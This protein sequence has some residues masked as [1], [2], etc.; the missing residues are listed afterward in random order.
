VVAT[1]RCLTDRRLSALAIV[2]RLTPSRHRH[3]R[4][5]QT[6]NLRR[7]SLFVAAGVR[8]MNGR[9]R[10][11]NDHRTHSVLER[12]ER[13]G[14]KDNELSAANLNYCNAFSFSVAT[15]VFGCEKDDHYK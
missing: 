10:P 4:L 13:P 2:H 11:P 14:V 1:N 3:S 9:N 8:K 7:V 5:H 6:V 12:A 15:V